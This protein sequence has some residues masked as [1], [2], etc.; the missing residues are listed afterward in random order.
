LDFEK[1][2]ISANHTLVYY[3]HAENGCYFSINTPKTKAGERVVPMLDR[4]KNTFLQEKKNQ[5]ENFVSGKN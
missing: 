1:G 5:E 4:V 2:E 3:K